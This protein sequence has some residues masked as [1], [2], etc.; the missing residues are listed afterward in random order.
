V[1]LVPLSGDGEFAQGTMTR[2]CGSITDI[3]SQHAPR[4]EL[5]RDALAEQERFTAGSAR[6][7]AA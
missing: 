2:L 4:D 1:A 5:V 3:E 7:A 6:E